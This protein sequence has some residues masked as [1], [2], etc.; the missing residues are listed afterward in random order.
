MANFKQQARGF[1]LIELMIAVVI[2]GILAAVAIPSYSQYVKKGR[3]QDAKTALLDYAARQERYFATNNAYSALF[4]P[5]GYSTE[6][7]IYVNGTSTTAYYTL[8]MT[9]TAIGTSTS[10]VSDFTATAAPTLIGG[11][12]TD[13]C[14]SFIINYLG[15]QSNSTDATA[16]GC[17]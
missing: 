9:G 2:I 17:W 6:T 7:P 15:A 3:R 5:L 11:Q 16:T 8:T 14:K 10:Q 13:T 4:K 12:S 1:T